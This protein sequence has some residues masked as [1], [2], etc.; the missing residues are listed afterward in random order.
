MERRILFRSN[1]EA[2]IR[3]F[4]KVCDHFIFED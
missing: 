4:D 1:L 2:D 3:K